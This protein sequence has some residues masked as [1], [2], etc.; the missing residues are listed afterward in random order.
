MKTINL[1]AAPEKQTIVLTRI[2]KKEKEK[3]KSETRL[4]AR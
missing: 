4:T 3:K 2:E 1:S